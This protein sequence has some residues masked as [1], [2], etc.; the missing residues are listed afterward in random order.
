MD[1]LKKTNKQGLEHGYAHREGHV[2]TQAEDGH[3]WLRR[4]VSEEMNPAD[5]LISDFQPLKL[6][7]NKILLFKPPNLWYFAMAALTN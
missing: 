5:S 3:L 4:E 7:E 2:N 6:W 1:T